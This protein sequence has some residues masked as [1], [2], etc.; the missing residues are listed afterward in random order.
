[1]TT[2]ES[3]DIREIDP[4]TVSP[5]EIDLD[6]LRDGLR[7]D[8]ERRDEG[9]EERYPDGAD[10]LR[11]PV[12]CHQSRPEPFEAGESERSVHSSESL[13]SCVCWRSSVSEA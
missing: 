3:D 8:E 6:R 9:R 5:E 10:D 4:E 13:S 1:M 7:S 2:A 11:V 12:E